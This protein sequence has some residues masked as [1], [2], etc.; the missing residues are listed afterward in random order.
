MRQID[1]MTPAE[2]DTLKLKGMI[3]TKQMTT[4]NT[5]YEVRT[6][7]DGEFDYFV[8]QPEWGGEFCYD[9]DDLESAKKYAEFCNGWVVK[10]T[11][12]TI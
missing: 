3:G 2:I 10:I 11:A 1:N 9:Q 7:G 4:P 12:E 8:Q 5:Y 6:K